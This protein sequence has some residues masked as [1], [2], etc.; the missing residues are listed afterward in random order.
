MA[1]AGKGNYHKMTNLP[2]EAA[3]ADVIA[4]YKRGNDM[5]ESAAIAMRHLKERVDAGE[6]GPEWDWN[7]YRTMHLEPYITR[8]WINV[9]LRLA[10]SGA[11]AAEVGRNIERHRLYQRDATTKSRNL[12]K[13]RP[14]EFPEGE[15]GI[16]VSAESIGNKVP[17]VA[18]AIATAPQ[19]EREGG[20]SV[21]SPHPERA[22][23]NDPEPKPP[24]AH[25]N[26]QAGDGAGSFSETNA[27]QSAPAA[28][29]PGPARLETPEHPVHAGGA[30]G[31]PAVTA[32]P[33]REGL[34]AYWVDPDDPA[35]MVAV[36]LAIVAAAAKDMAPSKAAR[37]WPSDMPMLS[38]HFDELVYWI[39][40]AAAAFRKEYGNGN[41][42]A[43]Q[44]AE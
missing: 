6:A 12:R 32:Q 9:Q 16:A 29:Q 20:D 1:E 34:V 5:L 18:G 39:E 10:P 38:D 4:R 37:L 7:S 41:D 25:G 35:R 27:R 42:A 3:T 36:G 23:V 24:E 22:A 15:P 2:L 21:P 8:Q 43:L 11:D 26:A 17:P 30:G 14:T 31:S 13:F 19:D 28:A 40:D 44:A 33:P